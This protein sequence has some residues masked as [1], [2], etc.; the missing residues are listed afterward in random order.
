MPLTNQKKVELLNTHQTHLTNIEEYVKTGSQRGAKIATAMHQKFLNDLNS[1]EMEHIVNP[2][3]SH[4]ANI[5]D[6]DKETLEVVNPATPDDSSDFTNKEFTIY[7]AP[8]DKETSEVVNPATPEDSSVFMSKE[9]TIYS[10]PEGDTCP[11]PVNGGLVVYSEDKQI[12]ESNTCPVPFNSGLVDSE[13]KEAPKML[14]LPAPENSY[15]QSQESS[16]NVTTAPLF[17]VAVS[18]GLGFCGNSSNHFD[19]F[20]NDTSD[21]YGVHNHTD[22]SL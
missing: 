7:S 1:E 21:L 9:L 10:P 4:A 11:V 15:D 8:E 19:L 13:D 6:G 12:T 18:E 5:S 17:P 22:T 14:T 16:Y 20:A 3:I 2:T